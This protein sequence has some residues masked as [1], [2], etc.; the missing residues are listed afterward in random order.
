M[1]NAALVRLTYASTATF[2]PNESGGIEVSVGQI[3]AESRRNNK[4]RRIG[5]VLHYGNGYFFQCLEGERDAVSD[6]YQRISGDSRHRDVKALS[7][8][9]IDQRMF[10]DWSMKY[11]PVADEVSRLLAKR[12]QAFNPY[13]FDDAMVSELLEACAQGK[14]PT[15][16]TAGTK[17]K[18]PLWK[19]LFGKA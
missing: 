7:F 13:A 4:K 17:P 5:G 3:L 8:E 15:E 11:L 1:S 6:C 19:R 2:E 10:P 16:A 18:P 12:N 9:D 14:D